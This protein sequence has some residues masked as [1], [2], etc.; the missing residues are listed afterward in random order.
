MEDIEYYK[1][2]EL[3]QF[4]L[5]TG[6]VALKNIAN[7]NVYIH[8]LVLSCAIRILGSFE[9]YLTYNNYALQLL[10]YFVEKYKIIYGEEYLTHN[11]HGLI[12]LPADCIKYG[13]L[14]NFSSFIFESYLYDIKKKIQTSRHPL[15][16][17]CNRLKEQEKMQQINDSTKYPVLGKQ[18]K[19]QVQ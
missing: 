17:I 7:K 1:A 2:T 9:L 10:Q 18:Y 19:V 13:P 12:H 6:P 5:Y 11:V 8:F 15:Q 3:R 14:E 4:L 16:Q